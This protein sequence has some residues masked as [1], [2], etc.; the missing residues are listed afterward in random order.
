MKRLGLAVIAAARCLPI[1]S[2]GYRPGPHLIAMSQVILG[3]SP[4]AAE[5]M[6]P[7]QIRNEFSTTLVP[8]YQVL[9]VAVYPSK[10]STVISL[11]DFGLRVDGRLIRPAAPRTIAARNSA[12][13]QIWRS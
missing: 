3:L 1:R 4:V 10:G 7:E 6:D 8:T 9:E 5:V 13:S 2:A 12:K 11:L